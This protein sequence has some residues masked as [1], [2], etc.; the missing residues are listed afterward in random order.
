MSSRDSSRT[1]A[2]EAMEEAEIS[3]LAMPM[4]TE[5]TRIKRK[6]MKKKKKKENVFL[7]VE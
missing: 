1:A 7:G 4:A 5:I 6:M 3:L 2:M